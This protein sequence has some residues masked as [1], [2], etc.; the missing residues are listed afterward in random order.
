MPTFRRHGW[1]K[2][3]HDPKD[4]MHKMMAVKAIPDTYSLAQF[5]PSVRDQ[6]R[7]GSCVGHGIGGNIT[8]R[9]IELGTFKEWFSPTWIYNGARYIEGDL[10]EDNGCYPRDA[11]DWLL[12]KG[13]LL[14]HLWPYDPNNLDQ[15]APSS[16]L[17]HEAAKTPLIAYYRVDNGV[18]GICSAIAS[19]FMVSIGTPWFKKWMNPMPSWQCLWKNVPGALPKVTPL[20]KV[21]GGH[22]TFLYGYNRTLK[23]FYGQNSW[24]VLW[25]SGGRYAMPFEAF[26]TFK[27]IGGYDAHY[28]ARKVA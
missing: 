26:D 27:L 1:R 13:C 15:R 28:V 21:V 18:D 14:E 17:D 3:P 7:V 8:A 6:G 12:K 25:G 16:S 10:T 24:G 2:D 11:L 5:L 9:A 19:G 22:E 4:F 20:D 23:L